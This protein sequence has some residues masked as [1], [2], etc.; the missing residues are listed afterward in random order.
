MAEDTEPTVPDRPAPSPVVTPPAAPSLAVRVLG[1]VT[2]AIAVI[3][4]VVEFMN[5]IGAL[6]P[7]H[8]WAGKVMVV[9]GVLGRVALPFLVKIQLLLNTESIETKAKLRPVSSD[10]EVEK[11]MGKK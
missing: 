5:Q 8:G 2:I 1:W 3:G 6:F 4:V 9:A 7:G 10:S 11:R